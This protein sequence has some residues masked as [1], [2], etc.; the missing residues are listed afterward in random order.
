MSRDFPSVSVILE[1]ENATSLKDKEDSTASVQSVLESLDI[2]C[3]QARITGEVVFSGQ[4]EQCEGLVTQFESLDLRFPSIELRIFDNSGYGYFSAKSRAADLAASDFIIFCDS[5]CTYE[6]PYMTKMYESLKAAPASVVYGKTFSLHPRSKLEEHSS[7]AWLFPP[8]YIGYG[9]SWPKSTW[10]N[11]MA[12]HRTTL[13]RHPL[14]EI[15]I[16]GL[17]GIET[18]QERPTWASRLGSY[19]I[20]E[21]EVDALAYHVQFS[22]RWEW[23]RRQFTHG[24][25]FSIKER[26]P[27]SRLLSTRKTELGVRIQHLQELLDKELI[28]EKQ[29]NGARSFLVI[30]FLARALGYLTVKLGRLKMQIF[31]P[32][33]RKP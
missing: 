23:F 8:E 14:P 30:A 9:W 24:V 29:Y 10:A 11:S 19:S 16:E 5:D 17:P 28:T 26:N 15:V 25:G 20:S 13:E 7:L 3:N 22:S 33:P 2:L 12:M 18:K 21:V 6:L 32:A 4:K 31:W 27:A 1:L